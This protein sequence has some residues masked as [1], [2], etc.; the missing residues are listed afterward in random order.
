MPHVLSSTAKTILDQMDSLFDNNIERNTNCG[1][2]VTPPRFSKSHKES[3]NS[4]ELSLATYRTTSS[5]ITKHDS[6]VV[7]STAPSGMVITAEQKLIFAEEAIM[8]PTWL[9]S[10]EEEED[11]EENLVSGDQNKSFISISG[12]LLSGAKSDDS[13]SR[14]SSFGSSISVGSCGFGKSS[15][16][17]LSI[18]SIGSKHS[19]ENHLL[20]IIDMGKSNESLKHSD[21]SASGGSGY[22]ELEYLYN[23]DRSDY[24]LSEDENNNKSIQ[25][26]QDQDDGS[27]DEKSAYLPPHLITQKSMKR[28]HSID[29]DEFGTFQG[30]RYNL[31]EFSDVGLD[32]SSEELD[33][34]AKTADE[35][36]TINGLDIDIQ[37]GESVLNKESA[38]TSAQ[39]HDELRQSIE[40]CPII[41][42][43]DVDNC[44][45]T[46]SIHCS[47]ENTKN[48]STIHAPSEP[49]LL[50][51]NEAGIRTQDLVFS[52]FDCLGSKTRKKRYLKSDQSNF[53]WGHHV[54]Q[55]CLRKRRYLQALTF[56]DEKSEIRLPTKGNDKFILDLL[57]CHRFDEAI[58][59]YETNILVLNQKIEECDSRQD[60]CSKYTRC[61]NITH[62]NLGIIYL[63][64][65]DYDNAIKAL[66][67]TLETF[68]D[69]D[70]IYVRV[71][72]LIACANYALGYFDSAHQLWINALTI[73]NKDNAIDTRMIL[74]QIYNNIGC[75]LF[76]ISSESKALMYLNK[77]IAILKEL[78]EK[79]KLLK[80]THHIVATT[81][82]N[83]GY[84]HLC[85]KKN[86]LAIDDFELC[87]NDGN[88]CL[89]E[90]DEF[91]IATL[92]YLVIA[93]L[94]IGNYNEALKV[95]SKILTSKI[96]KYNGA[97]DE[98]TLILNKINLLQHKGKKNKNHTSKKCI[99]NIY[100]SIE[101]NQIEQERFKKLLKSI[102]LYS[103]NIHTSVK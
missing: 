28:N 49:L 55:S 98:C 78:T 86:T 69:D 64:A 24:D 42:I 102:G 2:M 93:F 76:E 6:Q 44:Y 25:P 82:G 18:S 75:S 74:A 100:N 72:H 33:S 94:R 14:S 37:I 101:G 88:R 99:L 73:L 9:D 77:S 43:D 34:C 80:T 5:T 63:M 53:R 66:N 3:L 27:E 15:L 65:Y 46:L 97:H 85:M 30:G 51:D 20:D 45:D 7:D 8:D 87:L 61:I 71:L 26:C 84:L 103:R 81:R 91:M 29:Y 50:L 57:A 39:D 92:D 60:L 22:H 32:E 19:Y 17:D 95:Y 59:E 40:N 52:L 89:D 67:S 36:N 11:E 1:T 31:D 12:S 58:H 4:P 83:I 70:K 68:I 13:K 48:Y 16:C 35:D 38:N 23:L 56:I 62:L 47:I 10:E 96:E 54:F 21:K 41:K 90:K 79:D